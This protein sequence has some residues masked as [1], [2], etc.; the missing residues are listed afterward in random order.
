MYELNGRFRALV[1]ADNESYSARRTMLVQNGKDTPTD[2]LSVC[3]S[4]SANQETMLMSCI[5]NRKTQRRCTDIG[6]KENSPKG[7]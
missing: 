5:D 4:V 6:T 2:V 3:G 7:R 1:S